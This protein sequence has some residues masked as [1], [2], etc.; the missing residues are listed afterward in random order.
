MVDVRSA[1]MAAST[2]SGRMPTS[3]KNARKALSPCLSDMLHF[4][5]GGVFFFSNPAEPGEPADLADASLLTFFRLFNQSALLI[6]EVGSE[7]ANGASYTPG[8][9]LYPGFPFFTGVTLSY[10][11]I[12]DAGPG[13]TVPEPS[14]LILLAM[15][16]GLAGLA[17]ATRRRHR[18]K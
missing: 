14:S 8:G 2:R 1:I 7:G 16:V 15:G 6:P 18:R 11:I 13:S 9:E 17:G 10:T 12:S 3:F 4:S 5:S